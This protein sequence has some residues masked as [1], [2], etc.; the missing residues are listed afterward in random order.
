M[1]I[2]GISSKNSF[3]NDIDSE[4]QSEFLVKTQNTDDALQTL[5]SF[6]LFVR[7]RFGDEFVC[8]PSLSRYGC[9]R[10]ISIFQRPKPEGSTDDETWLG[11]KYFPSLYIIAF[12]DEA[13]KKLSLKLITFQGQ[14]LDELRT[15][16]CI[17]I[18]NQPNNPFHGDER[19]NFIQK[20]EFL[21]IC[22]GVKMFESDLKK[23]LLFPSETFFI[24][25]FGSNMIVKSKDCK[26]V[27]AGEADGSVCEMCNNVKNEGPKR[28]S[29]RGRKKRKMTEPKSENDFVASHG[30]SLTID[31]SQYGDYSLQNQMDLLDFSKIEPES[32][33][34][35]CG[36]GCIRNEEGNNFMLGN[37]SEYRK[38]GPANN[39][40]IMNPSIMTEDK[41]QTC[42]LNDHSN[43]DPYSGNSNV[44][45]GPATSSTSFQ[46]HFD[47]LSGIERHNSITYKKSSHRKTKKRRHICKYCE[48]KA[49]D[50]ASLLLHIQESHDP[51]KPYSCEN[52]LFKTKDRRALV[53]HVISLHDKSKSYLC[54]QCSY[55]TPSKG[56]LSCH[57]KAVHDKV[58][59]ISILILALNVF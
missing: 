39:C 26:F 14:L 48:H 18:M 37:S 41:L 6:E 11:I 59:P 51:E 55:T 32:L 29:K 23:N 13:S 30:N 54:E 22:R 16:S 52:C 36:D 56:R 49:E 20:L 7:L 45:T 28:K 47:S 21:K 31:Y 1:E 5:K 15:Q 12:V 38:Q 3:L 24:E 4:T 19:L 43:V 40:T 33:E 25:R 42:A 44:M 46:S 57:V 34:D 9:E 8:I 50:K 2:T 35:N 53:Q 58:K 10:F 27:I 17:D